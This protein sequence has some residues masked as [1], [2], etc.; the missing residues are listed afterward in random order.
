MAVKRQLGRLAWVVVTKL[1]L[2]PGIAKGQS[3]IERDRRQSHLAS[4]PNHESS[5]VTSMATP[6]VNRRTR[7]SNGM[8]PQT[9][10]SRP[11][12]AHA[13]GCTAT[14]QRKLRAILAQ[15]ERLV[16][17]YRWALDRLAAGDAPNTIAEEWAR[18]MAAMAR[19]SGC[20][21]AQQRKLRNGFDQRV[22]MVRIPPGANVNH[23]PSRN[24][25]KSQ[26]RFPASG[27]SEH[28]LPPLR[29]R[30]CMT[31]PHCGKWLSAGDV[32]PALGFPKDKTV[33]GRPNRCLPCGITLTASKRPE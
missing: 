15:L 17:R 14:Q 33:G 21:A 6:N 25:G 26:C 4:V 32:S 3:W 11:P 20:T 16:A 10:N 2:T 12:L 31:S 30:E 7:P 23:W 5:R 22:Q 9:T 19:A 18:L 24:S 27:N 1:Y 8:K 13:S 29:G 28:R